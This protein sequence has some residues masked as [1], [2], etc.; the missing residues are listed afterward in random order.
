VR[1]N[2]LIEAIVALPHVSCLVTGDPFTD[3]YL[4]DSADDEYNNSEHGDTDYSEGE[5]DDDDDEDYEEGES[6][7]CPPPPPSHTHSHTYQLLNQC[8][9][10]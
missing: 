2:T 5:D 4:S 9:G 10:V 1:Q 3:T 7:R 6:E 8:G